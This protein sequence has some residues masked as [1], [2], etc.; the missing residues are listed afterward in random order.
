MPSRP[1]IAIT[2]GDPAGIGPEIT[3]RAASDPR[4]LAACDPIL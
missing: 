2:A 1:R 4:V 3:A